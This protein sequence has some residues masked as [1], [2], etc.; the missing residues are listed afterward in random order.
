MFLKPISSCLKLAEIGWSW[1]FIQVHLRYSENTK[2]TNIAHS[3]IL[4]CNPAL[5]HPVKAD[6]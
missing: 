6:V 4:I 3:K 5:N 1:T 2:M